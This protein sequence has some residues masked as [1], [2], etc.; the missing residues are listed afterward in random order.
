MAKRG[1]SPACD[2][3]NDG[4]DPQAANLFAAYKII[5]TIISRRWFTGGL[6]VKTTGIN[7]LQANWRNATVLRKNAG[8]TGSANLHHL[9]KGRRSGG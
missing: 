9:E 7:E 6:G 1:I 5:A 3:R 8:G 4:H 2:P